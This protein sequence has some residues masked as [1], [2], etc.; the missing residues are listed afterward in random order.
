M[1][2]IRLAWAIAFLIAAAACGDTTT[3]DTDGGVDATADVQGGDSG[4]TDSGGTDSGG[5]DAGGGDAG[6]AGFTTSS[7]DAGCPNGTVCVK[8]FAGPQT[9]DTGCYPIGLCNNNSVCSCIGDC[10]CTNGGASKCNENDA[11]V[12]CGGGAISRR[13]YKTDIDYVDEQERTALAQQALETR[14]AEY[15]YKAEPANA[16]RHL[17]FIIDDQPDP[18]PAVQGDRTH[19]DQY[20]YTSMLLATVQ[21]QQKQIDELRARLDALQKK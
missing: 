13:A 5:T 17:G 6:C 7:C 12:L 18:S 9:V 10:A 14:L 1:R 16:K 8:H 2:S 4:G 15:R 3:T 20:G 21:E 19:V 11:G